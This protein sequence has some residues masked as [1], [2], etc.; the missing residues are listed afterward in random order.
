MS[1]GCPSFPSSPPLIRAIDVSVPAF[2]C[3]SP[4]IFG[5]FQW[6]TFS[7]RLRTDCCRGDAARAAT[8]ARMSVLISF[9]PL[10]IFFYNRAV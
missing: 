1:S 7:P 3:V 5:I 9:E 6:M 4:P 2:N 8:D 10:A